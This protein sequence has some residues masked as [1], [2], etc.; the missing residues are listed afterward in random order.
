M[1]QSPVDMRSLTMIAP[2]PDVPKQSTMP[3]RVYASGKL[4]RED[5]YN[6]EPHAIAA[7]NY[8]LFSALSDGG[9]E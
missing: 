4:N 5:C 8:H 7:M 1:E 3:A 9:L 6:L 2:S